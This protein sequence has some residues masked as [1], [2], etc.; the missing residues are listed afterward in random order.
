MY[1]AFDEEFLRRLF[2]EERR[3]TGFP[4]RYNSST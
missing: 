3:I 2:D 4:V 1:S